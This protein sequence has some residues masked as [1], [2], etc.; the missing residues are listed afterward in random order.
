MTALWQTTAAIHC[1]KMLSTS[2][3]I[4]PVHFPCASVLPARCA[5][6]PSF[7]P[8]GRAPPPIAPPPGGLEES[9]KQ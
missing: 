6:C 1:L 4:N 5:P 8:T 3:S 9:E 7:P 2:I